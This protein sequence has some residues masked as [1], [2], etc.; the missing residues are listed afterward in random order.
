MV[1]ASTVLENSFIVKIQ[2]F[3]RFTLKGTLK[4]PFHGSNVGCNGWRYAAYFIVIVYISERVIGN[5]FN[6]WIRSVRCYR[7][8]DNRVIVGP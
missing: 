5:T 8:I 6:S 4:D 3:A 7:E 2:G 1:T